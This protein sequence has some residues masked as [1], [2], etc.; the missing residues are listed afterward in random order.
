MLKNIFCADEGSALK[1]FLDETADLSPEERAKRFANNKVYELHKLL[2]ALS[3]NGYSNLYLLSL[4]AIQEVHNSVAQEGQCRVRYE[5]VKSW[6]KRILK[7]LEQ[8]HFLCG[9]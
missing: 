7:V 1:K 5:W 6:Q 3:L 9:R 8:C 4:K 2:S